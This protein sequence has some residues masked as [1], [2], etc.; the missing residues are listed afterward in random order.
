MVKPLVNEIN[1]RLTEAISSKDTRVLEL[2]NI[3]QL[4]EN[5][6][7]RNDE[8]AAILNFGAM[9]TLKRRVS[10]HQIQGVST[11]VHVNALDGTIKY[12]VAP[13]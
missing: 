8:I 11:G 1:W 5:E 9:V 7:G 10:C 2:G 13:G 4:Y 3:M 6:R 12:D